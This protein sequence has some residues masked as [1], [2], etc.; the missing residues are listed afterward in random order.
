[1]GFLYRPGQFDAVMDKLFT[2]KDW[3]KEKKV[4]W[5]LFP[6]YNQTLEGY[7]TVYCYFDRTNLYQSGQDERYVDPYDQ[8]NNFRF[9]YDKPDSDY[10]KR[11]NDP[12]LKY[13]EPW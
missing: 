10:V 3:G 4:Y 5:N 7:A 1:M 6:V 8:L 12:T 13:T 11:L 2:E 9:G